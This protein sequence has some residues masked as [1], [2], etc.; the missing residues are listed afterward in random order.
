MPSGIPPGLAFQQQQAGK[1]LTCLMFSP[2]S[3]AVELELNAFRKVSRVNNFIHI[4]QQVG[5]KATGGE[6]CFCIHEFVLK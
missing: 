5:V 1:V 3:W 4:S 2:R 6:D